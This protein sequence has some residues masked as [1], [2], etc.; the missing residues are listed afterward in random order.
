[1]FDGRCSN[2]RCARV[3]QE[4]PDEVTGRAEAPVNVPVQGDYAVWVRA[5][6]EG[7]LECRAGTAT[8]RGRVQSTG[9]AWQKLPQAL[10]L[11]AGKQ[12]ITLSSNSDGLRLDL[13][14]LTSVP[15]DRPVRL[16][17]RDPVPAPVTGLK[18][19]ENTEEQVRLAWDPSP[20][21]DLDYY[22]V[23]VGESAELVPGNATLLCSGRATAALDW[24]YRPGSTLFYKVVAVNKRGLA[25][26]PAALGA[27]T[28]AYETATLELPA[29]DATLSGGLALGTA[30][31]L[32]CAWLPEP[33]SNDAP[34]PQAAWRFT[35]PRAGTYYVWARYT[36]YDAKNV[37]LFWFS[38]SGDKRLDGT[39]WRL[40]LPCTLTRHLAGVKPGEETWFSDKMLSAYWAG[41]ID[42][43]TLPAGEQTLSVGF[44]PTQAPNGPRL[45]TVWLSSDPSWRPPGFDPRVDFV[46]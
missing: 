14:L 22:S 11:A 23:Y 32:E 13:L 41:P 8:A 35:A 16:D 36:T 34:R 27:R 45:A 9:W 37:G 2:Y 42:C 28:P 17:D 33:K 39:N 38:C 31:G 44:S 5:K 26:A 24:G 40:R 29:A 25:S 1:M 4:A 30:K 3:W 6:G 46:K 18:V 12:V 10:T 15:G 7:E 43:V 21:P 19:T 20:D